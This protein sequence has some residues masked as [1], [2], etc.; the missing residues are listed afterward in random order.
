VID[1]KDT[2]L[3][4]ERFKD[5]P[6]S[7]ISFILEEAFAEIDNSKEEDLKNLKDHFLRSIINWKEIHLK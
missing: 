1:A 5:N 7:F 3:I 4:A 2:L 6:Y